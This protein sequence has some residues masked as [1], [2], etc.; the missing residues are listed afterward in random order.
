MRLPACHITRRRRLPDACVN[1]CVHK[2]MSKFDTHKRMGSC[3]QSAAIAAAP[4][5]SAAVAVIVLR[6]VQP[7]TQLLAA[8]CRATGAGG[9]AVTFKPD[10]Y[11]DRNS[12]RT[13]ASGRR[14]SAAGAC[15]AWQQ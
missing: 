8:H 3:C 14:V 13:R 11:N 1:M 2:A 4:G 6:I 5:A 7:V 9:R 12:R 15:C 10:R